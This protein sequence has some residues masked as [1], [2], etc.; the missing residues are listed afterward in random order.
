LLKT[1]ARLFS[2]EAPALMGSL[3]IMMAL[4]V[5]KFP[6]FLV[7]GSLS[8]PSLSLARISTLVTVTSPKSSSG[9]YL[10]SFSC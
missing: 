1:S 4:G 6:T 9:N 8:V 7:P 10:N 5:T 2:Q 3:P